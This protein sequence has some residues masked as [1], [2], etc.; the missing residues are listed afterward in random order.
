MRCNY[1]VFYTYRSKHRI[2]F[3]NYGKAVVITDGKVKKFEQVIEME[4]QIRERAPD[5]YTD[6]CLTNYILLDEA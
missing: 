4:N 1:C 6:I 5:H 2:S 3:V